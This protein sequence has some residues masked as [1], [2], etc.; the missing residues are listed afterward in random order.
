MKCDATDNYSSVAN[1]DIG[2]IMLL[3]DHEQACLD[4]KSFIWLCGVFAISFFYIGLGRLL[5]GYRQTNYRRAASRRPAINFLEY[6]SS[7]N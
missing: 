7:A 1:V 6:L 3:I 4:T 5:F 2:K